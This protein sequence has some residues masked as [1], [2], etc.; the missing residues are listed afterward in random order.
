AN[1]PRSAVR[2]RRETPRARAAALAPP[3]TERRS[4][5]DA[6]ADAPQARRLTHRQFVIPIARPEL[7]RRFHSEGHAAEEAR[8]GATAD[9]STEIAPLEERQRVGILGVEPPLRVGPEAP[10]VRVGLRVDHDAGQVSLLL[11]EADQDDEER[12]LEVLAAP[13]EHVLH[14]LALER[15]QRPHL[16]VGEDI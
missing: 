15:A 2:W 10:A 11:D 13:G 5:R 9:R 7:S 16:D 12:A 3:A 4:G 6:A 1:R 14:L 8:P